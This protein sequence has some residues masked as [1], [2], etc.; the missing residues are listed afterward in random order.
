MKLDPESAAT[1]SE[2]ALPARVRDL[3]SRVLR[4]LLEPCRQ[5]LSD[6][7]RTL[8]GW[9][10]QELAT[11]ASIKSRS[12]AEQKHHRENSKQIASRIANA[13]AELEQI[14]K[15]AETDLSSQGIMDLPLPSPAAAAP[16]AV[17]VDGESIQ[18]ALA[19]YQGSLGAIRASRQ[20]SYWPQS[21]GARWAIVI[22]SLVLLST[23]YPLVIAWPAIVF[24]LRLS[25]RQRAAADYANLAGGTLSLERALEAARDQAQRQCE[26]EIAAAAALIPPAMEEHTAATS[27]ARNIFERTVQGITQTMAALAKE[28]HEEE[29]Q[30]W[31]ASSYA[32][33][34]WESQLWESWTPDPSPEFAARMG[35]LTFEAADLGSRL[36]GVDLRFRL[37]ALIPFSDGRCLLFN[38]APRTFAAATTAMQSV[39]IRVLANTP[40]GKAR[41]TFIDPVGLGQN[42]AD[43]LSLGD[44]DEKLINGKAW[45]E[46]QHIEQ[47]LTELTEHMETVIQKYLRTDFAS[48]RDYNAHAHEVAEPFRFLVIFDFPASFSESAARR[49]VSI[50]RNGPRCGVFTF[51]IKDTAKPLPYGFNLSDLEQAATTVAWD[52]DNTAKISAV[53]TAGDFAK[54]RLMPD[55]LAGR[56]NLVSTII[57]R[58]G[59]TAIAAMKV[60]VP[61]DKMVDSSRPG[62]LW[63]KSTS[64]SLQVPLGPS[65]ARKLQLLTLGEGLAHHCLIVGRTGSGKTNLMHVII[66]GLALTYSPEELQ[67]YLIDF[68]GG[69]GFKP[70]AEQRLPHAAV[71]A[72]ESE[73]EFGSSVLQGLDQELQRRFELFR[74]A[75]VDNLGDYRK[76]QADRGVPHG[77]PRILLVVD[78]FQELFSREDLIASQARTIFDRMVRQGRSFGLHILLG[79]QSLAGSAQLPASTMGQ[80]AVRIALPCSDADSRLILAQDNAAARSLSR[81]GEAIYNAAAGLVEGNN[82]FQAARLGDDD[83]QRHL[84]TLSSLAKERGAHP[85]P[86][87]FE[88]NEPAHLAECAPLLSLVNTE[89]WPA[90]PTAPAGWLGE[91]IAVLPPVAAIFR[92]QTGKHL[93]IVSR[94]EAEGVGALYAAWISLLC[95]HRPTTARFHVLDLS[96]AD[97]SW[98][99]FASAIRSAFGHEIEALDRRNTAAAL[100]SLAALVKRRI[101]SPGHG[102]EPVFLVIQGLHRARDLRPDTDSYY[103]PAGAQPS[104]AELLTQILRDGPEVGVH[105]L[106]WCD[107]VTNARRTLDRAFGEFGMRLAG[108]MSMEESSLFLDCGDASRLDRPHRLL[109]CDEDRPGILQKLRPYSLPSLEWLESIAA[110]QRRWP[111]E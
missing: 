50:V 4:E 87:I 100:R 88:G 45:T 34:D 10:A 67:L 43:F 99:P 57:A 105:V 5:K 49:L 15:A 83:L 56:R 110:Q 23:F 68:K 71:I 93:L 47:Q 91:P 42:V 30:L 8:A 82:P 6:A 48:I 75:G 17:S 52:V 62:A 44:Y 36:P 58:S 55:T 21:V 85:N 27:R 29:A 60:E 70:Y 20:P 63:L 59:E 65:G 79:T 25:W 98:A 111:H 53:W 97:S 92:R 31:A 109:F 26:K 9:Q 106:A 69:V 61:F 38:C 32:G 103:T 84:K 28:L 81:P 51:I 54:A 3:A 11:L 22:T 72:I 12:E 14:R 78:E 108:P 96:A 90:P 95:Q 80:M 74:A 86:I 37:P 76:R 102:D 1:L 77:M 2:F 19:P 46:P 64:E 107:T 94:D 66:T 18:Q 101:E 13:I 35:T 89:A 7:E 39:V 16:G 41:F 104:P 73:R 24:A 40:P 33:A